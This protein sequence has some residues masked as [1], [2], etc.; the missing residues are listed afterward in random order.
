MDGVQL[1]Q[2]QR[3]ITRR[4]F[5]FFPLSSQNVQ[6]LIWSNSEGWKA[7]STLEPTKGFKP[8]TTILGIWGPKH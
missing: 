5:T 8:E 2:A 1:S 7:E 4:Q 3:A 6:I